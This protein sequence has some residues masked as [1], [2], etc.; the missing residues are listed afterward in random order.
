MQKLLCQIYTENTQQFLNS[1]STV[2]WE[3]YL[4]YLQEENLIALFCI[5][6]RFNS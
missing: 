5:Y 2:I 3:T 6:F 4:F 1:I